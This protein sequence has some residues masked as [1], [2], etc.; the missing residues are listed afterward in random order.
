MD[1]AVDPIV[2]LVTLVKSLGF[3]GGVLAA[4][5]VGAKAW[6]MWTA[7]QES[8]RQPEPDRLEVRIAQVEAQ[9]GKMAQAVERLADDNRETQRVMRDVLSQLGS[10]LASLQEAIGRHVREDQDS[11]DAAR[12]ILLRLQEEASRG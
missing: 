4:I 2:E 5:L 10:S 12:R 1:S 7:R 3:G 9:V 11:H 8:K 6:S